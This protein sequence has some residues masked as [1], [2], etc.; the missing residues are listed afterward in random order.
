MKAAKEKKYLIGNDEGYV[1]KVA[2]VNKAKKAE[3]DRT[4]VL[5]IVEESGNSPEFKGFY[6]SAPSIFTYVSIFHDHEWPA[7]YRY[8]GCLYER[9]KSA[10]ENVIVYCFS[11]KLDDFQQ[12]SAAGKFIRELMDEFGAS[13]EQG[14]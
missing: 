4:R 2:F 7:F 10:D 5:S 8:Q 9:H 11:M 6:A 14:E 1:R 3:Y 13:K 12:G